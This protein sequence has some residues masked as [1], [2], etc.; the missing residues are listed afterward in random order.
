MIHKVPFELDTL[1]NVSHRADVKE[2]LNREDYVMAGK[3]RAANALNMESFNEY[4]RYFR[5]KNKAGI[6]VT[7]NYLIYLIP[8]MEDLSLPYPIRQDEL[9]AIF[10]KI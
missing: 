10:F 6:I 2:G 9:L 4:I 8:S 7:R 1:L 5:K 3:F